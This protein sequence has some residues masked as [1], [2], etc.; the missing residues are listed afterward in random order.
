MKT[1]KEIYDE[2]MLDFVHR[3]GLT[4]LDS[5][6]LAAR[7]YA[8]AA[9]IYALQVQGEW[10]RKQSF[11][12]TAQGEY[13]D[14]HAQ[15][16]GLERKQAA[17]AQGTV[18]IS[19]AES[20]DYLR[21]VPKGTV[22]ITDDQRRFQTTKTGLIGR[23]EMWVDVPAQ[24]EEPGTQGN[25]PAGAITRFAVTPVS[26][27]T[28]TNLEDFTGGSDEEG[29]EALRGRVLESFRMLSNGANAAYYRQLMMADSAVA[30]AVVVPRPRGVG[31]ADV[32][33]STHTGWPGYETLERLQKLVDEQRE[34][35]VDVQVKTPG[36]RSLSVEVRVAVEDGYDADAV[37]ENVRAAIAGYFTGDLL[38]QDILR[39]R[40]GSLVFGC[41]GVKNYTILSPDGDIEVGETEIVILGDVTVEDM[42]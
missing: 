27:I 23:G 19:V 2:M 42:A 8:L 16:R 20:A 28:C 10:V 9:Q 22:L 14:R 15:M 1:L 26:A 3:T 33:V 30:Q 18:R 24:A 21:G 41:E 17:C 29:D 7:M 34:I 12:Q 11:P 39:A 32:Y 37:K 31:S 36:W 4:T 40:L 13:L 5:C 35:A 25:V 38:G 6:D